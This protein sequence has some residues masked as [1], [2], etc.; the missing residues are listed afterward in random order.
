MPLVIFTSRSSSWA[1]SRTIA[2]RLSPAA[3]VAALII[4][5]NVFLLAQTFGIA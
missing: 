2:I 5:L 3:V 4:G 1:S